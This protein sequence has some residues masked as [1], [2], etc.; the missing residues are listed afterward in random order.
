MSQKVVIPTPLRRFTGGAESVE[1]DATTVQ[2]VID[3]LDSRFPGIRGGVCEASGALRR[4]INIYVD[5]EDVRFLNDLATP[6]KDGAE[7]AIIPAI[8]GGRS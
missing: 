2:D 7:I 5:G 1:L 6:V 3:T 8:A 4:F